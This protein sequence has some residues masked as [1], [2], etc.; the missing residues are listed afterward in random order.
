MAKKRTR[1]PVGGSREL[2]SDG[3]G[4]SDDSSGGGNATGIPDADTAM[5]PH[6]NP[7]AGN[8]KEDRQKLFPDTFGRKHSRGKSK[9]KDDTM[10]KKKLPSRVSKE[11]SRQHQKTAG[12][13]RGKTRSD[14][15][16][17]RANK[18]ASGK[19]TSNRGAKATQGK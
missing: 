1:E 19:Q 6:G 16:T 2:V 8:V 17:T 18:A 3:P 15:P 9:D 12:S 5:R 7:P 14:V 4:A 11:D 10:A 13:N